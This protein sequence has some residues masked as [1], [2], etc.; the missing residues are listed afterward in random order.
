M[1]TL[2][3]DEP[4][5]GLVVETKDEIVIVS[6]VRTPFSRFGGAL[7]DV[8]SIDLAVFAIKECLRR[9]GLQGEDLDELYYGMCIQSEAALESN[10]NARQ[11]MLRAGLPATLVSLT[12][13]RACCSSLSVVQL[14]FRAL[15]L[16]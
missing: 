9:S 11:A 12:I 14:G 1:S 13:D 10:V 3:N 6:A 7:R 15:L 4:L 16:D 2:N 8:H 5:G